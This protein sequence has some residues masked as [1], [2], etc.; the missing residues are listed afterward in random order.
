MLKQARAQGSPISV[1]AISTAASSQQ[2]AATRPAKARSEEGQAVKMWIA[3]RAVKAAVTELT[4]GR[5][6]VSRRS[7]P[8]SLIEVRHET[9]VRRRPPPTPGRAHREGRLRQ[10]RR[11]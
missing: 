8:E 7:S 4:P 5:P 6:N 1:M 2:A 11:R 10:G 9:S 3:G